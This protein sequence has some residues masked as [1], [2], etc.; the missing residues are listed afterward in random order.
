M[1]ER[2]SKTETASLL[3][4]IVSAYGERKG[5]VMAFM[6]EEWHEALRFC[7]PAAVR[8][9]WRTHRARSEF[10]PTPAELLRHIREAA[11]IPERR[12]TATAADLTKRGFC[13]NGRTEAEEIAY[14]AAVVLAAKREAEAIRAKH[15]P[16]PA[17][18]AKPKPRPASQSTW[19]SD[20]LRALAVK[21][22]Y[23]RGKPE[24]ENT[25]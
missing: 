14:R 21:R 3:A 5:A 8:D 24:E 25:P 4:R 6:V 17:E 7:E 22:G 10:W 11:P 9:A 15:G 1:T 20:Q 19:I 12:Y 2:F 23:W 13:R 18:E 16:D